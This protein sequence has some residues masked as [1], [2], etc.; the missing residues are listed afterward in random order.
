VNTIYIAEADDSLKISNSQH[1]GA[2]KLQLSRA[3]Y[4]ISVPKAALAE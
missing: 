2:E 1:L 4:R 3:Y